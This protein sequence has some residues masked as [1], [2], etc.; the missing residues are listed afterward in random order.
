MIFSAWPCTILLSW[1]SCGSP[2][3]I[4]QFRLALARIPEEAVVC[5]CMQIA[6][7]HGRCLDKLKVS[8][9]GR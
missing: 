9:A 6:P 1:Q 4:F 5:S 3:D 2:E 8:R 7:C